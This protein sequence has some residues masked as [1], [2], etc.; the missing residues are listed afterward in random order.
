MEESLSTGAALEHNP[1]RRRIQGG[2]EDLVGVPAF[3]GG[4]VRHNMVDFLT[5]YYKRGTK[6]FRT[7]STLPDTEAILV[8]ETLCDDSAFGARFKDPL[9]YLN[10]RRR[11]EQW[12]RRQFII[13]GGQPRA[14][15]P[16]YMVLG[17][18]PWLVRQSPDPAHHGE[19]RVPLSAFAEIDVSFTYPDSMISFWFATERPIEYYQPESHGRIFTMSEIL[20][21]VEA[22][23]LPEES[24]ETSLPPELAPYIEAQVWNHE[25][26]AEYG[27]SACG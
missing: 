27:S 5:Y 18:S 21:I 19:I 13:K 3:S 15:Y 14:A 4:E 23:G 25:V 24:W 16:I 20:A 10:S 1:V 2:V 7:L 9:R 12:V 22:K 26:L 17:E 8:M 6:P 11:T